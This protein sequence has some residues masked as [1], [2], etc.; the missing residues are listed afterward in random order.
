M[1]LNLSVNY[2]NEKEAELFKDYE[3]YETINRMIGH[4]FTINEDEFKSYMLFTEQADEAGFRTYQDLKDR[5]QHRIGDVDDYLDL[6]AGTITA[7]KTSERLSTTGMTE[8]I[9]VSLGLNV[10]NQIHG[11]TEADWAITQNIY[12]G[13]KRLK[14]FDYQIPMASDG[15]RFIQV[16]NKGC[17]NDDNTSKSPSVSNHYRSIKDKKE[18]IL[19]RERAGRIGRHTNI[20]YGTIGVLDDHNTAKVWLV[21]PDPY[22]VEWNPK[23]Y[24]LISR[25][26]YYSK[27]FAEIGINKNIQMELHERI[28]QIL[29]SQDYTIYNN[30]PLKSNHGYRVNMVQ[31]KNFASIN[32]NE[33]LGSFFFIEK[34]N[35]IQAFMLA[36]PKALINLIIS[37]NFDGI[38]NYEYQNYEMS[39]KVTIELRVRLSQATDELHQT[40][41]DFVFNE[42]GKRYDYQ[43]Y[44]Q[45]NHISSGRIFGIIESK[46]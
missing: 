42:S 1:S 4:K 44:Q 39:D 33:V 8:R 40:D 5:V 10:V 12:A 17:I 27:L 26:I 25:L 29:D 46:K 35:G 3:N 30:K 21:D 22:E 16:E 2:Y 19:D 14:D 41:L 31:M 9:G 45:I 15:T 23:K 43:S 32:Y 6:S 37:Q 36:M 13:G 34:D 20:Y 18:S 38:L 24:R 7:K 11:L 28:G